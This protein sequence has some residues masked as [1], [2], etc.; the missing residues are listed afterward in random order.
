MAAFQKIPQNQKLENN[1]KAKIARCK[2]IL[3][4]GRHICTINPFSRRYGRQIQ[5]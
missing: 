4:P 1:A 2:A 3:A 5:P